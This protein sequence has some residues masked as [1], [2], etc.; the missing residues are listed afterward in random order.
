MILIFF[1]YSIGLYLGFDFL[2]SVIGKE[3][4]TSNKEL[5]LSTN[6]SSTGRVG[7]DVCIHCTFFNR[8]P[9]GEDGFV[10]EIKFG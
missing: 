7:K 4:R 8:S 3:K 5:A 6:V 10:F 1:T 2:S 9:R